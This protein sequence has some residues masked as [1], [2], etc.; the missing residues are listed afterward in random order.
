[1]PGNRDCVG[2]PHRASN[3]G[4]NRRAHQTRHRRELRRRLRRR[5]RPNGASPRASDG[6]GDFFLVA[7][8]MWAGQP[9]PLSS[10]RAG[11]HSS[12][13]ADSPVRQVAL[14][15]FHDV[16]GAFTA[17]AWASRGCRTAVRTF[18][19]ALL[20]PVVDALTCGEASESGF[21][22]RR[23]GLPCSGVRPHASRCPT[24]SRGRKSSGTGCLTYRMT[25]IADAAGCHV[26]ECALTLRVAPPGREAGSRQ[27]RGA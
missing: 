21:P 23:G 22:R 5:R 19:V 10:Q 13:R 18:L 6:S 1:M 9:F 20:E 3:A 24:K 12:R 7:A 25:V 27:A 15:G 11:S 17:V 8:G 26:V 16:R 2:R 14:A 4:L